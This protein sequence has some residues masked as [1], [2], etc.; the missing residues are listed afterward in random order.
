MQHKLH[1]IRENFETRFWKYVNKNGPI[2]KHV[3]HIGQCWVW[4]GFLDKKGIGHL[5]RGRAGEGQEG[6]ARASWIV[7][8]GWIPSGKSVLHHCDNPACVRIDH[9]YVGTQKQNMEDKSKRRRHHLQGHPELVVG[10]RNP[11]AKL[12]WE[13]VNL[14]R[15]AFAN[16]AKKTDLGRRYGVTKQNIHHIVEN[17]TW[18]LDDSRNPSRD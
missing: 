14:I 1:P 9:L 11:K 2:P 15:E 16:G 7:H 17:H 12:T 10:E 8:F 3:P 13:N 18:V 5:R 6:V 4:T